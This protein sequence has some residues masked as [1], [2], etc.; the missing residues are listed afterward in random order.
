MKAIIQK[1]G[2][3]ILAVFLTTML[4]AKEKKNIII[5]KDLEENADV[6]R[7]KAGTQWMGKT[8][9]F[10]FG[11]YEVVDSKNGPTISSGKSSLFSTQSESKSENRFSFTL[12]D[13]ALSD[14]VIVNAALQ[15]TLK[16]IQALNIVNIDFVSIYLG[17]DELLL[18]AEIFSAFIH[19]LSNP[20]DV[21]FLALDK[22]KGTES[23]TVHHGVLSNEVRSIDIIPVTSQKK[24][25]KQVLF[26][27]YGYEFIENGKS[28]CALQYWSSGAVGGPQ[29]TIWLRSDVKPQ[30]KIIL[31]GAIT[32]IM[33]Y[34]MATSF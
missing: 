17:E 13:K 33:Q 19:T 25:E 28:I 9:K 8:F 30:L 23:S 12:E 15:T 22:S 4:Q 34:K 27:A 2:M 29:S 6:Y 11:G 1:T 31:A 3:L 24:G 14:S 7:V 32:A 18:D 5:S 26:P 10:K 21:W 16:E 20:D